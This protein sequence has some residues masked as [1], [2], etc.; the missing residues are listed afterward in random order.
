MH[1]ILLLAILVSA[2][3]LISFSSSTSHGSTVLRRFPSDQST[4]SSKAN[5]EATKFSRPLLAAR[6][7]LALSE[8]IDFVRISEPIQI[9]LAVDD[10]LAVAFDRKG[11][12]CDGFIKDDGSYGAYGKVIAKAFN[13][14][15]HLK[16]LLSDDAAS[17]RGMGR[18]CPG[19]SRL[20]QEDRVRFWVWTFASIAWAESTCLPRAKARGSNTAAVGLLQMEA[21]I[22]HRSWRGQLCR[23]Y[24]DV[25]APGPNLLCG[26]EIMHGHFA[27]KYE[28]PPNCSGAS[29][30][31]LVLRCSYWQKLRQ[32]NSTIT[33]LI[34][35][36]PDCATSSQQSI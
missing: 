25:S 20:D 28:D 2:S 31:G 3:V 23:K 15:P 9:A 27:G 30:E 6:T 17:K 29:A 34:S 19:F 32:P 33:R 4:S 13:E 21:G 1:K 26:M 36:F 14:Y 12:D 7:N 22:K 16:N 8:A 5:L 24:A 11:A 35:L 18:L 10:G